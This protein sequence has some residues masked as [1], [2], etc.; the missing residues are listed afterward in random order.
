MASLIAL[1]RPFALVIV[2]FIIAAAFPWALCSDCD[3]PLMPELTIFWAIIPLIF[4]FEG[5]ALPSEAVAAAARR[6]VTHSVAL[7]FNLALIPFMVAT[8]LSLASSWHGLISSETRDGYLAL[9]CVPTTTSMC[10][11]HS[12]AAG[13]NSSLAAFVALLGN[14]LAV[15]VTPLLLGHLCKTSDVDFALLALSVAGKMFVPLLLGQI[16]R[17]FVGALLAAHRAHVQTINKLLVSCLL[18][19]IFSDIFYW[20]AAVSPTMLALIL[21]SVAVLHLLFLSLAWAV[22]RMLLRLSATDCV[23]FMFASAQKTVVLGLPLL[24]DRKSVV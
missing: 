9:S 22:G 10:V 12:N 13:G 17:P 20:G 2:A 3:A 19:Q 23:P 7:T 14:I 8:F 4:L 21:P 16:L 15:M 6:V 1:M 18:L 5:L 24:R 11:M